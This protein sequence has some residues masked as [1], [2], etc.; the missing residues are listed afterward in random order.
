MS[1]KQLIVYLFEVKLKFVQVQVAFRLNFS[2]TSLEDGLVLPWT[3]TPAVVFRCA[4]RIYCRSQQ[5]NDPIAN[6]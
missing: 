3:A 4:S 2:L 6:S 1:F 5:A